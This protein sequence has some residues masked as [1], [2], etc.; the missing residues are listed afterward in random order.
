MNIYLEIIL[1]TLFTIIVLLIL[2]KIDG[3][4]QISQLSF[5]DYV[6]GITAG[7]VAAVMCVEPDLPLWASAISLAM[8][9]LSGALFSFLSQKSILCRRFLEGNP[10]FVIAKGEILYKGL[11]KARFSV[12][13]LM[14]ELRS[15]GY[16]DITEINYAILETNGNV[17]VM[18]KALARP[19]TNE[20]EGNEVQD[21]SVRADVIIDGK[22]LKGNLKAFGK[23]EQWLTTT[24]HT[25]GIAH[26]KDVALA[27]LDSDDNLSA[28][29]KNDTEVA[30]SVFQ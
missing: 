6:I 16:F 12:N 25:Q 7:S 28:Y 13:D 10:I 27:S 4:K 30:R 2:T 11:K 29:L 26:I 15:Q 14:R 23:N 18:P 9:M 24:L 20:D 17:S 8:F 19:A 1:R 3:A 5:F 21:D 22:I